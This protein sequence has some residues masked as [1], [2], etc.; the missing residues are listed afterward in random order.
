MI[1]YTMSRYRHNLPHLYFY[2]S[3]RPDK[4]V[5][6]LVIVAVKMPPLVRP[7]RERDEARLLRPTVN[8]HSTGY[9]GYG[10]IWRQPR[11]LWRDKLPTAR[12]FQKSALPQ[13]GHHFYVAASLLPHIVSINAFFGICIEIPAKDD[14]A[15]GPFALT[16]PIKQLSDHLDPTRKESQVHSNNGCMKW[17]CQENAYS[18]TPLSV[19]TDFRIAITIHVED[20]IRRMTDVAGAISGPEYSISKLSTAAKKMVGAKCMMPPLATHIAQQARNS[21]RLVAGSVGIRN[22]YLLEA[23]YVSTNGVE[24]ASNR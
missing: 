10:N 6:D 24:Q 15:L 9:F 18:T 21:S 12:R 3:T 23:V 17:L 13:E 1:G 5:V 20:A 8:V 11:L 19:S 16:E 7:I 22:L 14:R 2:T 4:E